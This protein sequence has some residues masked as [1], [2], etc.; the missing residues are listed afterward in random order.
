VE[1]SFPSSGEIREKA[2]G[3]AAYPS[4]TEAEN[5]NP[6]SSVTISHDRKENI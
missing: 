2:I 6:K 3:I 1:T 4:R 5:D